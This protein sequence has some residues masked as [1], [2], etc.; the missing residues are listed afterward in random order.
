MIAFN[1]NIVF[2]AEPLLQ[3]DEYNSSLATI[4]VL[5]AEESLIQTE[6]DVSSDWFDMSGRKVKYW[7]QRE[8][9]L[10]TG[11]LVSGL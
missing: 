10:A 2:S 3:N 1:F 4:R 5:P 11:L 8:F 9:P 6:M 7:A